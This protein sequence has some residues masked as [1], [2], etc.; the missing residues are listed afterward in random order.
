F[1]HCLNLVLEIE[2]RSLSFRSDTEKWEPVLRALWS[3]MEGKTVICAFG[4]ILKLETVLRALR[5][6]LG[7]ENDSALEKETET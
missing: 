2:K 5:S 7:R 3:R 6:G 1:N 4:S